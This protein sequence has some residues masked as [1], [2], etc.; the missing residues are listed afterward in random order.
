MLDTKRIKKSEV[1][2]PTV[3]CAGLNIPLCRKVFTSNGGIHMCKVAHLGLVY[4]PRNACIH[5]QVFIF[6]SM[7]NLTQII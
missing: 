6:L 5:E 3:S 7:L 1:D 4:S 2:S